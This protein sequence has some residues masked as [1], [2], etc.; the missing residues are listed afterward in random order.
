MRVADGNEP[1]LREHDEGERAAHLR[2]GLDDGL[3]DAGR[4]RLRVEVQHDLGVAA[5]LEDGA[6]AHELVA[7]LVRVHQVAVVRDGNLPVPALDQERLR[8]REAALTRRRIAHVADR[9]RPGHLRQHRRVEHVG[10]MAHRLGDAHQVPVRRGD[11][12]ALLP[13]VLH[14]VEPEVREVRGLGVAVD[15]E[16]AAFVVE[17]VQHRGSLYGLPGYGLQA[18]AC[19][20]AC[21]A[22]GLTASAGSQPAA[23]SL[24][25]VL[26]PSSAR[27]ASR[28]RCSRRARRRRTA[29]SIAGCT[30]HAHHQSRAAGLGQCWRRG[31]PQPRARAS[32]SSAPALFHRHDDSRGRLTEERAFRDESMIDPRRAARQPRPRD[33]RCRSSIRPA[34]R[35]GRLRRSRG[36]SSSRPSPMTSTR[37]RCSR[38]SAVEIELRRLAVDHAVEGVQ[39]LAA[40]ELTQVL[41]EQ[42]DDVGSAPGSRLPAP[43]SSGSGPDQAWSLEPGAWSQHPPRERLGRSLGGVF[44]DADDAE[45]GGGQ[46]RASVGLVVEADVAAGDRDVERAAGGANALH[47]LRELPHD[48]RLLGVAEVEVVGARRSAARPRTRRCAPLPRPRAARRG[49]DRGSRTGRCRRPTSPARARCPSRGSRPRRPSRAAPACWCAPCGRTGDRSSACWPPMAGRAASRSVRDGGP[50]GANGGQIER[51]CLAAGNRAHASAG[52]RA[53]PR[54]RAPCSGSRRRPCR[55]PSRAAGHRP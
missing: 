24:I 46:N 38:R 3:L 7:Q 43:A 9:H 8:V 40:A 10:D 11:A 35:Q 29:T 15:A 23:C 33:R 22:P 32:S 19:G 34:R 27:N 12:G 54:R 5:R 50:C 39:V 45:H 42:D 20:Q 1:I 51:A 52:C 14:G 6:L 47:G 49:T 37:K 2:D 41:A 28:S 4:P 16:D 25:A 36:P 48:L 26:T 53:A 31:H 17:L 44:D 21:R 30:V 13:A 18:A 55:G